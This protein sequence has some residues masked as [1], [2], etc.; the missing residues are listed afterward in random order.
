[1]QVSVIDLGSNSIR[2]VI[3]K[4]NGKKLVKIK[5]VKRQARSM[6][7]IHHNIMN[8]EG[9]DNII[10]TLKELIL[11]SNA[12]DTPDIR[13]FATAGIRNIENST[14]VRKTIESE[15]QIKIDVL[16]GSEESL[17]GFEGAK[18][19]VDLSNE[20][21]CVDIGGGS[22]EIS[23][24]K[25]NKS[26]FS[27]S[28]PIGSLN[29]YLNFVDN[30]LPS[31][32]EQFLMQLEIRNHLDHIEWLKNIKTDTTVAIGGSSR[33]IFRLHKAKYQL[34]ESI[35]DFNLSNDLMSDYANLYQDNFNQFTKLVVDAV[36]ERL[37]TIIPGAMILNEVVSR[38][39]AKEIVLSPY[40]VREGYLF[41]RVLGEDK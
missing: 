8:Y 2:L 34:S 40:G 23:Y 18:R 6:K 29:M 31:K 41:N 17:F 14:E 7:F 37:T 11:I 33:A 19:T 24:F 4:W 21:I 5:D 38:T 16:E 20:G 9:I 35:Y 22:T 26:I 28:I 15:I 25:E 32:G 36:P 12:L 10:S 1:M 3:Y 27:D 30:V 13:I 39:Q